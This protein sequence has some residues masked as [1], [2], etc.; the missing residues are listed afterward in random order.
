MVFYEL[1]IYLKLQNICLVTPK[2]DE[3]KIEI[4]N[5]KQINRTMSCDFH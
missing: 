4:L 5:P 2:T 1:L 3:F